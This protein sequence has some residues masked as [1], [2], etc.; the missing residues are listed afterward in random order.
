MAQAPKKRRRKLPKDIDQRP[1]SEALELILGKRVKKELDRELS[2]IAEN[3]GKKGVIQ[4]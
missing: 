2:E 4:S 1:D 3:V